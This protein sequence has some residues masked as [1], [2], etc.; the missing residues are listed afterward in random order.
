MISGIRSFKVCFALSFLDHTGL[1]C[2]IIPSKIRPLQDLLAEGR[3]GVQF[4]VIRLIC[5]NSSQ[6]CTPSLRPCP[7]SC[8][9]GQLCMG[10]A[11]CCCS[12]AGGCGWVVVIP[13]AGFGAACASPLLIQQG[14]V[15]RKPGKMWQS[16]GRVFLKVDIPV[17]LTGNNDFWGVAAL[18]Y[19]SLSLKRQ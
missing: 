13:Q 14:W 7:L 2:G 15:R 12:C 1:P 10:F 5:S 18:A 8:E 9:G 4:S 17:D 16:M 6:A 19:S 11:A 3:A